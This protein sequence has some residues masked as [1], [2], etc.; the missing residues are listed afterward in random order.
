[1]S[2]FSSYFLMKEPDVIDYVQAKLHYFDPE[3][4]LTCREIGDGNLNYV[5]RV[6]DE[7]SGRSIIVKQAGTHLRISDKMTLT[8]D[9][10]RIEAS[11]LKLQGALC[12]GLV[13]EVY[14]YD[15]VM[16]AMI[17]EDMIGHTMMRTGLIHHE[18]Y[19]KFPEQIS[20]FLVNSL[21]M[22]TDIVMNHQKRKALVREF[23]NPELCDITENLVFGEPILNYNGRND[24]FPP[25]KD[26]VEKEIYGDKALKAEVARLKF[27]FMNH[28]Q[29]LI[30]GDLHTGSVFINQEHT[31]VFDPEFAFF[32]PMGYDIGNVIAN[33]FFAWA[34]GNAT[35]SDPE[36]KA[37]FCGWCMCAIMEIVDLFREKFLRLYD[38]QVTEPLAKSDDFKA[39]YLSEILADTAG[40][41][42]TECIRRIV[43]MAH[44][45]DITVIE[46][47]DKRAT[48]EK[49][50]LTFAKDLIMHQKDFQTA[51]EYYRAMTDAI[52]AVEPDNPLIGPEKTILDYD[53]VALDD[54]K[55]A[56]VIIDQTKLPSRIEILS[57]TAQK[58]IWDAI[59]LL[60]V[61]GAPAIGVAAAIGIYLAAREIAISMTAQS[62]DAAGQG[63]TTPDYNE[64]LRRF[65]EASAYLNSSRPTAVNLSW[66]L[67]R[68][69][70]VVLDHKGAS[71]PQIVDALHDEALAI[72]EEDILV[73][74]SIGKYGLS[75]VKPGDSLLT[76]C[77]AGQLATVKYGTAT[78]PMY[79]GQ[80]KG[81]NFKV[82]C[83]ETRPLL[84]GARLTSFELSS[85][86]LDVTLLCDNMSASLMR[87]GK[88]QAVFV[89]C[90]RVAANGDTANKIGTSMAAL[91]AKRYNVPFYVC[92]PTS[93]IDMDTATGDDIVIEQRK[94]EEV[95]DMWYEKPMAAPGVKVYNP[96]F[97]VTDHDLITGIVT[98]FGIAYPPYSESFQEIFLKKQIRDT[99][100]RMMKDMDIK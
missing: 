82:Y 53:T 33:L 20:T 59:Y 44:N 94:P 73:C 63:E 99:V 22:T 67:R 58:D 74:R 17:M 40:Y 93:T 12:P 38:E 87:E 90:D 21:L 83:D 10:G 91:A 77:N 37:Q 15:G 1:M 42:G 32:G 92:A 8:T 18:M 71:V 86:G 14:L 88:I 79:L 30:H 66:A 43:G 3:S 60:K 35:I 11:I 2:D 65:C 16:C 27:R 19:P 13:P 47:L 57:L 69:E 31:F 7:K 64:F 39:S 78:A 80:E 4:S 97:D 61:R 76:H 56:L 9:R 100:Q 23:S 5:F 29:S 84:Q 36:E 81:Y 48:A 45:K 55:H 98:E 95:T 41:A 52:R 50:L 34:N 70:N 89:G 68:M 6:K 62:G 28:A 49:I 46:D 26:F 75:L 24:V 96:A 51:G 54:E 25:V 85:A 72:R